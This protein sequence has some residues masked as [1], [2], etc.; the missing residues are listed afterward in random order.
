METN[1]FKI[2]SSLLKQ[3]DECSFGGFVLFSFDGDGNPQVLSKHDNS[4]NAMA[5]QNFIINWSDAMRKI[6]VENTMQILKSEIEEPLQE[7]ADDYDDTLW[8]ESP[9]DEDEDEE[10]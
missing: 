9:F 7:D 4:L 5:V 10:L 2:P 8:D 1:G 6:S 3:F